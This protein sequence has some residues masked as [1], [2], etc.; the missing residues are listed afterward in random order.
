MKKALSLFLAVILLLSTM[1][2]VAFAA[3]SYDD[4]IAPCYNNT[5]S[6]SLSFDINSSGKATANVT[7]VGISGRTTKI[8][9]ETKIQRRQIVSWVTVSGASWTETVYDDYFSKTYTHQL[10]STGIYRVYV[11]YTVSGSGGENDVITKASYHNY[12]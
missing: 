12:L 10:S 4:E 8:V 6:A 2:V 11:T 7:C 3:E 1:S 5:N 9:V